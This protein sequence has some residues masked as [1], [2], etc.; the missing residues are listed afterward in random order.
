MQKRCVASAG[1]VRQAVWHCSRSSSRRQW[2][3]AA[4]GI[5]ATSHRPGAPRRPRRQGPP[6]ARPPP[7]KTH[8]PPPPPSPSTAQ[9]KRAMRGRGLPA[10]VGP[11][12][13]ASLL[14][15]TRAKPE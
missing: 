6:P 7:P 13:W 5:A 11:A 3:P 1:Q 12:F 15:H 14:T 4:R 9:S 8:P 2:Q 10:T